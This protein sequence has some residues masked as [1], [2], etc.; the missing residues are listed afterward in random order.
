M[1][2]QPWAADASPHGCTQQRCGWGSTNFECAVHWRCA[3]CQYTCMYSG[4][5]TTLPA[6]CRCS[7]R[8]LLSSAWFSSTLV[9]VERCDIMAQPPTDGIMY[10]VYMLHRSKRIIASML[11]DALPRVCV[12]GP[13]FQQRD[14]TQY[15]ALVQFA[16][17]KEFFFFGYRSGKPVDFES[18]CTCTCAQ[19]WPPQPLFTNLLFTA[20]YL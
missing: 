6:P 17:S 12:T 19:V 10:N 11:S 7:W 2:C 4:H 18:P 1:Q 13:M 20:N 8:S 14:F 15:I 16:N 5:D 3:L 9:R